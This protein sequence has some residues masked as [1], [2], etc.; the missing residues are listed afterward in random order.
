S[1]NVR[2][3]IAFWAALAG[4]LSLA[5][6][7]EV[8]RWLN[9]D[10]D[11]L[12]G[13]IAGRSPDWL[14]YLPLLLAAP[15]AWFARRRLVLISSRWRPR[16]AG[17]GA[18]SCPTSIKPTT[19]HED[20]RALGLSLLVAAVGWG[21]ARYVAVQ[22]G[23]LPPA[24]HDEFSYLFQAQTFLAG[25]LSFPSH[26]VMPE[27]FDQMHVLNEGRFASRYFPGTGLWMTPFVAAGHPWWGH[28]AAHAF[29]S[30]LLFWI[31]RHLAN[32]A[33]GLLAGLLLALSPGVA[34]F[35]SLLLAHHPTLVGLLVFTITF[36]KLRRAVLEGT[37]LW[38]WALLTG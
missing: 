13:W 1:G 20:L 12:Q 35:S 23:D 27:L 4:V 10:E 36:L 38:P 19:R 28:Q 15:L 24:Y 31:G 16:V 14:V 34:L 17:W 6:W 33:V 29:A 3:S 25:Q 32:N 9:V 22:F 11:P 37:R 21:M 8:R 18:E 2:W 26:P 5:V 7:G 30:F